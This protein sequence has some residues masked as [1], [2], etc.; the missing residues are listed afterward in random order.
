MHT[1]QYADAIDTRLVF[2][3]YAWTAIVSGVLV[4][5]YW[6]GPLGFLPDA[7]T[8][9]DLPGVP[10][11]RF[12]V[13]RTIAAIVVSFGMC[14][15]GFARVEDPLSRRRALTWF[16]AAHLVGGVMFF[17][18]W[19][20]ILVAV[21][22]WPVIGWTPIVVGIVLLY[23][24]LTASHAPRWYRPFRQLIGDDVQGPVT[25]VRTKHGSLNALRSQYE[26]NIR[27]AAR[28]EE[29]ARLARDLHDAV[30]QQ[31]FAIQTSAATAQERFASDAAGA[32]AA[33]EQVRASARHAMTEMEALLG[34]LKADPIENT[35][36]VA[37]LKEQCD[38]LS[39]RTGAD[40]RLEAGTMPP[41]DR[42]FPGA[43]QALF[44]AGQ[45]ALSNI[46]R[47]AR[48][49]H[50]TVRLGMSAQHNLELSI[51]DDGAGCD[52]EAI[53]ERGMGMSNM[54][55]RIGEVG[56]SMLVH[57]SPGQG[58][59]V[60]FSVP[61]DAST[62]RDYAMKAGMWIG[63]SV[64]LFAALVT[65]GSWDRPWY[66]IVVAVAAVTAARFVAAWYR[67]RSHAERLI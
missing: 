34:Q 60:A 52:P 59:T 8:A 47:H 32:R 17:V 28:I 58:M 55:T 1:G 19:Q 23:V 26:Q 67:V 15:A 13:A 12:A 29:R 2:R 48:A 36:L 56:G 9:V 40:V 11:G 16:A 49:Q 18:Q 43:Q 37:A 45:E 10:V 25:F 51:R 20:A 4:Y 61:C 35:G 38:A 42:L 27:H 14:A 33:L 50:V 62:S 57:S 53:A 65:F 44:R 21:L 7:I 54:R 63:V 24:S 3:I 31:L 6:G 46:P 66:V 5:L 30:K 22:P 64:A 41:S 39:L